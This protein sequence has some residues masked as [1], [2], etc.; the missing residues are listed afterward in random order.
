MRRAHIPLSVSLGITLATACGGATSSPAPAAKRPPPQAAPRPF[1]TTRALAPRPIRTPCTYG[2]AVCECRRPCGHALVD[3]HGVPRVSGDSTDGCLY[4]VASAA[5]TALESCAYGA[6]ECTCAGGMW[7]CGA[8]PATE[9]A[10]MAACTTEDV[11]C[12]YGTATCTCRAVAMAGAMGAMTDA[13]ACVTP[14][15]GCPPAQ[16]TAGGSCT[17]GTGGA[18]GL[19]ATGANTGCAC[20]PAGGDAGSEWSCN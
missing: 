8:C 17:A 19:R 2:D 7:R 16:P 5:C 14:P 6:N 10:A 11:R 15:P 4:G 1:P 3:L 20:L 18:A 13:W 9:P 12:T